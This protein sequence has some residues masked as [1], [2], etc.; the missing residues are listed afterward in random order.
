MSIE[1]R[2]RSIY[3]IALG[4]IVLI[5]GIANAQSSRGVGDQGSV[6]RRLLGAGVW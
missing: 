5:T 4:V 6:E 3:R 1:S 2:Q